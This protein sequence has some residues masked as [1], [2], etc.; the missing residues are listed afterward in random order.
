MTRVHLVRHGQVHNPENL[1]YGRLPGWRLSSTGVEQAGLAATYLSESGLDA[2]YSSPLERAVATAEAIGAKTRLDVEIDDSLV[3]WELGEVWGGMAW[4]E[5]PTTHPDQWDAYMKRPHEAD[6]LD[7]T[8][9]LL[10]DRMV[11]A[12]LAIS[13]RHPE[14]RVAVVSHSDPL[15]AAALALTRE[16]LA[17]LHSYSHPTGGI[18]T[19]D[20]DV[21]RR[22]AV[23]VDRWP[24]EL[25]GK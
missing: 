11:A 25:P 20:V 2:V 17:S 19:L 6:F 1:M 16:D 5:I 10:A 4:S 14:G 3:E 13:N 18:V 12:I 21:E 15:K 23:I 22:D 7:E 9:D 24:E 8:L